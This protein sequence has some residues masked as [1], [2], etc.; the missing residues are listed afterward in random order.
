MIAFWLA[1]RAVDGV[2]VFDVHGD[3]DA[4]TAP[5][6]AALLDAVPAG[7][8]VVVNLAGTTLIDAAAI[9]G[10]LDAMRVRRR[11]GGDL[12]AVAA[13]GAVLEALE[14]AGAAKRLGVHLDLAAGCTRAARTGVAADEA[15][16]E[17]AFDEAGFDDSLFEEPLLEE[18]TVDGARRDDP[19]PGYPPEELS[20]SAMSE[21]VH[22]LLAAAADLP[23]GHRSKRELRERAVAQALPYARRLAARYRHRGEPV[24]D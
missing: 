17:E 3:L 6:L 5:R 19:G 2:N 11:R 4:A 15:A 9:A 1:P 12:C 16:D 23:A 20:A 13:R 18:S 21:V 22:R 24:E 14:V 10:L 7:T 8:G